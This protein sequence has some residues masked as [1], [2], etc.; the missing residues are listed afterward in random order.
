MPPSGSTKKRKAEEETNNK[1][2]GTPNKKPTKLEKAQMKAQMQF[3]AEWV[4]TVGGDGSDFDRA[5][6]DWIAAGNEP[7][8]FRVPG[9]PGKVKRR[10]TS[11][12]A[13]AKN[14]LLLHHRLRRLLQRNQVEKKQD[15][16][17]LHGQP[18]NKLRAL[19]NNLAQ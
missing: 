6:D 9:H 2:F 1:D 11:H 19:R 14:P 8:D 16:A 5:W 7:D 10:K 15:S 13:T 4:S 3:R 12:A 18:K 17:Q